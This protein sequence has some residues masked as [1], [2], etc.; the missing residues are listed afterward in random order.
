M[1]NT[2]SAI[3]STASTRTIVGQ[4]L[5]EEQRG[6]G[7]GRG[8]QRVQAIVGQL[9][10]EAAVQHQRAGEGEDDPQQAAGDFARRLLARV[11]GEAEQQQDHQREGERRVDRFLGAQLGAQVLG[12]D[13]QH[14]P[15]ERHQPSPYRA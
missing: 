3:S 15:D 8:D 9:A 11:E 1:P 10:R 6:A 4:R 5:A 14:L 13:H 2:G 7:N 12:H